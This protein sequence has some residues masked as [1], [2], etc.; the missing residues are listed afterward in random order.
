MW[1]ALDDVNCGRESLP[2][3]TDSAHEANTIFAQGGVYP[4]GPP[5]LPQPHPS[6]WY[7]AGQTES[8]APTYVWIDTTITGAFEPRTYRFSPAPLKGSPLHVPAPGSAVYEVQMA[9]LQIFTG[10]TLDTGVEANRRAFI[11]SRG[12]PVDPLYGL[13]KARGIF[14]PETPN[15][16][17]SPPV[18][19]LG[20]MP[21]RS[22]TRMASNWGAGVNLGS[23]KTSFKPTGKIKPVRPDPVLG[24]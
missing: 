3:L 24:K 16:T 21:D 12:E 14:G 4:D 10:V 5:K 9:E 8:G 22:V 19:L 7:I 11:N 17:P 2:A 18:Q 1:L 6:G 23:A 20:K 13:E 15:V